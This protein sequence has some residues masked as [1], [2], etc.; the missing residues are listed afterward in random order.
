M[1]RKTVARKSTE[2]TSTQMSAESASQFDDAEIISSYSRRQA[3]EDGVLVDLRQ[4]ELYDLISEAGFLWPMACTSTVFFECIDVTPAARRA[5]NDINGRLCDILQ[6][7]KNAMRRRVT[8][9]QRKCFSTRLWF[10]I[11]SSR[12]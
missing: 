11:G 3:I 4:G 8:S 5:G 10:G 6:T 9:P 2:N 12:R 7:M 1:A